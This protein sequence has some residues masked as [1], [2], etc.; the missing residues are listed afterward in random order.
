[1]A[2]DGAR[3]GRTGRDR[4]RGRPWPVLGVVAV[5]A[6]LAAGCTGDDPEAPDQGTQ[7]PV[8]LEVRIASC[9]GPADADARASLE[10]GIGDTL[11]SYVVAGFLG[12]YPR[13]DF[14]RSFDVFTSGAAEKA[15]GDIDVLTAADY[16]D[17]E[18]VDATR[19]RARISC[20]AQG[21]KVIGATAH[22]ELD[23]AAEQGGPAPTPFTLSGRFLLVP[24]PRGW[25]VFG[26]DVS[27]DDL[28]RAARS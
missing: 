13:E 20:L 9:A 26:Y 19:L 23:F 2:A 28:D 22:V 3:V 12:D 11:S 17:A 4:A 10:S 27:R 21:G 6:G 7:Q 1:M 14:V 25:S 5:L 8:A 18:G 16:Q 15:A 24:G